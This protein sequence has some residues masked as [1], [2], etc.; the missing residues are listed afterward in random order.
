MSGYSG[1]TPFGRSLAALRA[2]GFSDDVIT[3]LVSVRERYESGAYSEE[4]IESKR[5]WFVRW[6]RENGKLSEDELEA[7]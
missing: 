3:R 4:T 1:G 2:D 6:L 7:A 5:L